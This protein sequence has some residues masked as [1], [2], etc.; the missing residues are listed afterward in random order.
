M[1]CQRY[2]G[3]SLRG[4]SEVSYV[5]LRKPFSSAV[6]LPVMAFASETYKI[7][8]LG[9]ASGHVDRPRILDIYVH[10]LFV[11]IYLFSIFAFSRAATAAYGGSQA[12][13]PIGAVAASL[14]HSHSN[15]GSEPC[16]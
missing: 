6:F 4:H 12:R 9:A 16:L 10:S 2:S 5:W 11:F 8:S 14:H 7:S 15:L 1:A 3:S 13:G